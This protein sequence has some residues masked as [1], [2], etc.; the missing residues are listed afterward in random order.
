MC[1]YIKKY[2]HYSEIYNINIYIYTPI[3]ATYNIW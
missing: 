1:I 3:F 2:I